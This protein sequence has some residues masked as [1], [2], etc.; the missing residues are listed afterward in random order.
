MRELETII[1]KTG[2]TP[3]LFGLVR[4]ALWTIL[5]LIAAGY[6][7]P[8]RPKDIPFSENTE[9]TNVTPMVLLP[10]DPM[11]VRDDIPASNAPDTLDIA[12]LG[13]SSNVVYKP[14]TGVLEFSKMGQNDLIPVK[15][16]DILKQQGTSHAKIELYLRLSMRALE[17]YTLTEIALDRNPDI[18]VV[19]LNPFFIFNNHA[20]FKGQNHFYKAGSVWAKSPATWPW[21][22]GITSPG[23]HLWSLIE[24]RFPVLRRAPQYSDDLGRLNE[25]VWGGLLPTLKLPEA[26]ANKKTHPEE[27]LKENAQIYWVVYRLLRGDLSKIINDK[28]EAVNSLWYRQVAR[29]SNPQKETL[30]YAILQ[31]L[32]TRASQ[33]DTKVLLY[34]APLSE[35]VKQDEGAWQKYQDIKNALK[36]LS[37]E[38]KGRDIKILIDIPENITRDMVYVPDD[39]MHVQDSGRLSEY[40]ADR[41]LE[42]KNNDD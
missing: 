39:D 19:T 11:F 36:D 34:L 31:K 1:E 14:G 35:N 16:L 4:I 25:F 10:D 41:I 37:A 40:L 8:D 21:L 23:K 28:N 20:V 26:V 17:N 13:G 6:L 27:A 9:G 5:F 33:S 32:L 30:N 29:L 7:I 12:W 2:Y 15:V 38:Y 42:L 24:S 22:I 18:L 3:T